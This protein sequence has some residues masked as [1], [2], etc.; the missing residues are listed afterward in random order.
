[1]FILIEVFIALKHL[2]TSLHSKKM[3][4]WRIPEFEVAPSIRN[5]SCQRGATNPTH[6]SARL[7]FWEIQFATRVEKQNRFCPRTAALIKRSTAFRRPKRVNLAA[8]EANPRISR[9]FF[10]F[11]RH[12]GT[13]FDSILGYCLIFF[14]FWLGDR[15]TDIQKQSVVNISSGILTKTGKLKKHLA[16]LSITYLLIYNK[17]LQKKKIRH[18]FRHFSQNRVILRTFEEAISETDLCVWMVSSWS[19]HQSSS[20]MVSMDI[21][22]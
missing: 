12:P 6:P 13:V 11:L 15:W 5:F 10:A 19:K 22:R 21:L 2:W 14:F 8:F 16:D 18:I 4:K 7:E 17:Y 20:S 3:C 9:P 1:M